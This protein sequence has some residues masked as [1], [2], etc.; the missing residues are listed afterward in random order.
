ML[1]PKTDC[2]FMSIKDFIFRI[3]MVKGKAG[4]DEEIGQEKGC[5]KTSAEFF[6]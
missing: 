5:E 1:Y 6:I 3:G 4:K 2:T